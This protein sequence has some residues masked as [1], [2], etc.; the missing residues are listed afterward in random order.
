PAAAPAKRPPPL[1]PGGATPPPRPAAS[2]GTPPP[3]ARDAEGAPERIEGADASRAP[4][5][6]AGEARPAAPA[7]A[8]VVTAATP[9]GTAPAAPAPLADFRGTGWHLV[10]DPAAP[11][12]THPEAVQRAAVSPHHLAGQVTLAV[13]SA[14]EGTVEIRLDPPELGRVQIRLEPSDTGVRAVVMAERPETQDLLR[15]HSE[16]L[17]RDLTEAGYS[18]V[19]LDFSAGGRSAPRGEERATHFAAPAPFATAG[20]TPAEPARRAAPGRLDIRL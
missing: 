8:P 17:S 20:D 6:V 12:A 7:T 16:T 3:A 11:H 9:A 18:G 5:P 19:T 2:A 14:S 10:A 1:P 13:A 4:A 15:R